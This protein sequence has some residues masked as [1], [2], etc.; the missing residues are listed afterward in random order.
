MSQIFD[1]FSF[2]FIPLAQF[3]NMFNNVLHP[4]GMPSSVLGNYVVMC[5]ALDSWCSTQPF[6]L[7]FIYCITT[8]PIE[9]C[10]SPC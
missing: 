6:L 7:H 4:L 8:A 2:Q 9:S 3:E 5:S 10:M 1:F